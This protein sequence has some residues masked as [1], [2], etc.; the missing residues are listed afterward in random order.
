MRHRILQYC[1]NDFLHG[2]DYFDEVT[3]DVDYALFQR[4]PIKNEL[5]SSNIKEIHLERS[6]SNMRDSLYVGIARL[7]GT[8]KFVSCVSFNL[9]SKDIVRATNNKFQ[10]SKA[11]CT[12][13]DKVVLCSMLPCYPNG[14]DGGTIVGKDTLDDVEF[15]LNKLKYTKCII[16]GDFHHA[17]GMFNNL[18]KLIES[19]GFKSYLDNYDTF[20]APHNGDK[21]NLDRMISNI[22]NLEVSNIKVHQPSNPK[23]HLAISYDIDFDI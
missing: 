3:T 20:V 9:P 17:P 13:I 12:G 8:S 7:E 19:Y 18:D 2:S 23:T 11:L 14:Q 5:S 15:I 21:F 10:G 1:T 6:I 16:A 22:P 4:L